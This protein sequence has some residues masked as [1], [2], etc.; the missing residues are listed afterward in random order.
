MEQQKVLWIFFS[1]TLFL[2]VVV[3][4]GF[5]WFLPSDDTP[6]AVAEADDSLRAAGSVLDPI[7]WVRDSNE[8]PGILEEEPAAEG[9]EKPADQLIV[10][11][12]ADEGSNEDSAKPAKGVTVETAASDTAAAPA[13]SDSAATETAASVTIPVVKTA[14]EVS[15]APAVSTAART[16]SAPKPAAATAAAPKTVRVTQ[17]WIQAGSFK[18]QDRAER[19][20]VVLAEKG[21]HTRI[22]SRDV[23]GDTYFRVRLGPYENEPEA[24]KFLGWIRDIDSFETSYISEVYTSRA[25]N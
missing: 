24:K 5:V 12:T 25:I 7:L 8:I 17:Y 4:V 21:W 13:G 20:Q 9:E 10:Y 14:P 16:V 23:S 22:V 15:P 18:S 2:L 1:V 6:D 11:G 19:T 3:V